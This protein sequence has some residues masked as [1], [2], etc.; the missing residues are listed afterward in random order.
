[1]FLKFKISTWKEHHMLVMFKW[2]GP[3]LEVIANVCKCDMPEASLNFMYLS[4]QWILGMKITHTGKFY[5]WFQKIMCEINIQAA[6]EEHWLIMFEYNQL[7][8]T[9]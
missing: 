7:K 6:L 1:M 2:K 4:Y 9:H 8:P 3:K 5:E